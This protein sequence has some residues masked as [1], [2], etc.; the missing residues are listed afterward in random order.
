MTTA[1]SVPVLVTGAAGFVGQ[2]LTRS[3]AT[4]GYRVRGLVRREAQRGPL[5]A[6]G[7]EAMVGDVRDR[8]T[9]R[10]ALAGTQAVFH[11]SSLFRH[12]DATDTEYREVHVDATRSLIEESATVGVRRFIHCSTVGVH[13]H[14]ALPGPATEDAPFNPGDA[15]QRT[16]LEG[17]LAARETA[18]RIGLPLTV[19]R[20]APTYGPGDERLLKLIGGVARRRFVLLGSGAPRLHLIYVDDLVEG[21]RLA[22]ENPCAIGRTYILAGDDAPTLNE[23]VRRIAEVARVPPPRWRLPVWPFLA[24]GAVCEA[25]CAPLGVKPPIYRRRVRFFT[26]NRW[27][28]S[29]R[30]RAELGFTPHVGLA[31]G[32]GRT[33]QSYRELGWI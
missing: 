4:R 7:A 16:K 18:E 13:G 31:E 29:A 5:E 28:D 30:A 15:Y 32:L 17:E 3:L 10:R 19:I 24:A 23:L 25:V 12:P 26:N 20:P 11:L 22:A 8:D 6:I 27:F 33:L 21:Y 9:I 14:V 2:V 1:K